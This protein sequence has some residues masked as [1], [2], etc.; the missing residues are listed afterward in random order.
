MPATCLN[1]SDKSEGCSVT[2]NT[3]FAK[4]LEQVAKS[5]DVSG[6]FSPDA[7]STIFSAVMIKLLQCLGSPLL[8]APFRFLGFSAPAT[9]GFSS[10]VACLLLRD[11]E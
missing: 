8:I 4:V 6:A 5:L 9:L 1:L 7:L 10:P 2:V 3:L 11:N